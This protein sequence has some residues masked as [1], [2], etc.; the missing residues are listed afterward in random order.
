LA[1]LHTRFEYVVNST[2]LVWGLKHRAIIRFL[3][4]RSNN[5]IKPDD[6]DA[7]LS[8]DTVGSLIQE[9]ERLGLGLESLAVV[10]ESWLKE[11]I[12]ENEMLWFI[13]KAS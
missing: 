9:N 2:P 4:L 10:L 11:Q 8:P 6:Y 13:D 1:E 12:S 3:A 7:Y 5:M